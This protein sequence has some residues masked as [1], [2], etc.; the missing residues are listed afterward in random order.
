MSACLKGIN[1]QLA[2]VRCSS[3]CVADLLGGLAQR[4]RIEAQNSHYRTLADSARLKW[5]G[6]FNEVQSEGKDVLCDIPFTKAAPSC[7]SLKSRAKVLILKG[8]KESVA[9]TSGISILPRHFARCIQPEDTLNASSN[10]TFDRGHWMSLG[11]L[12]VIVNLQRG[13]WPCNT[14]LAQILPKAEDPETNPGSRFYQERLRGRHGFSL[15][16]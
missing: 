13:L 10:P 2:L 14:L 3:Y 1:D 9:M 4:S 11:K 8:I 6:R 12:A 7:D 15:R 16:V 5:L